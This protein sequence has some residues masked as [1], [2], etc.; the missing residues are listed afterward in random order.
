VAGGSA[1]AIAI[2]I[3]IAYVIAIAIAIAIAITLHSVVFIHMNAFHAYAKMG[4]SGSHGCLGTQISIT[5][6]IFSK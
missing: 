6:R 1:I 5:R 3:V 2:A 4:P